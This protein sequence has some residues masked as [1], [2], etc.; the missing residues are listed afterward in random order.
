MSSM[1]RENGQSPTIHLVIGGARE[2]AGFVFA[3][4][5][6][7][8]TL[9]PLLGVVLGLSQNSAMPLDHLEKAEAVVSAIEKFFNEHARSLY[10]EANLDIE[11][12]YVRMRHL[13][14]AL[15]QVRMSQS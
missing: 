1:T 11:P 12:I 15:E 2:K 4:G 6:C 10:E 13:R 3:S 14:E 5:M 7:F 8:I 9:L